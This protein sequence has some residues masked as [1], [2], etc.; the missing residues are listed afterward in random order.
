MQAANTPNG[1]GAGIAAST[2]AATSTL[3]LFVLIALLA[4]LTVIGILWGMR[5]KRRRIAAEQELEERAEEIDGAVPAEPAREAP[6]PAP[7]PVA[8]QP[9][10]TATPH[11]VD[12]A[13]VAP[14]APDAP[15]N[16]PI[17]VA[18]TENHVATTA[19]D[20]ARAD[21]GPSLAD[22]PVTQLKGLGPK[23]AA[24]LAALGVTTIGQIAA[25]DHDQAQALDARLGAFTGRMGRDRWIEQARFLAS[26]DVKGFEAVF[27]RL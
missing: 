4:V 23:V 10:Q 7:A 14:M 24:Q 8:P 17:A 15:A 16:E 9:T 26:G 21:T 2:G 5:L 6:P 27:G 1:A 19:A 12:T 11:A 3:V 13:P 18:P 20:I 22:G 25:L